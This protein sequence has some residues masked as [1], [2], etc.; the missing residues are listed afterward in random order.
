MDWNE[1]MTKMLNAFEHYAFQSLGNIK[2]AFKHNGFELDPTFKQHFLH[3]SNVRLVETY[4]RFEIHSRIEDQMMNQRDVKMFQDTTSYQMENDSTQFSDRLE[5]NGPYQKIDLVDTD[6]SSDDGN[7][8]EFDRDA[9]TA[10]ELDDNAL[11]SSFQSKVVESRAHFP[12]FDYH[13]IVRNNVKLEDMDEDDGIG[14]NVNQDIG[15]AEVGPSKYSTKNTKSSSRTL[16]TTTRPS[17][18]ASSNQLE[19]KKQN[20]CQLCG[21][22]SKYGNLSRHMRT[23]TGEKPYRCDICRKEFTR[24]EHMKQH[25]VTHIEQVPYHCLGCFNGFSQKT[26]KDAHEKACKNRRYECHICKK[27]VTSK[28]FNLKEHIRT[29]NGEK[30]FR[31]EICMKRFTRKICLKTHL[32]TIHARTNP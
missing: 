31:C 16:K 11:M 20:K 13:Q 3:A 21:Y 32:D 10:D 5:N 14:V 22:S 23:H 29:H 12:V 19:S 15:P 25:K 8:G 9:T 26:E 1:E 6:D 24:M 27:F 28:K 7:N 17:S 4:N 2:L 30:P 18:S